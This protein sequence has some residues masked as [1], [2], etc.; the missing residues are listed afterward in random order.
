MGFSLDV[1]KTLIELDT[2]EVNPLM[3]HEEEVDS[4]LKGRGKSSNSITA[5]SKESRN[6]IGV[7]D[8][9]TGLGSIPLLKSLE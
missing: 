3:T 1:M 2:D 8:V 5:D 7:E 6:F 9:K 4:P